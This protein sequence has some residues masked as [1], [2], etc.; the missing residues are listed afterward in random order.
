MGGFCR[1]TVS[2]RGSGEQLRPL[3][4]GARHPGQYPADAR[5]GSG[6][7][8]RYGRRWRGHRRERTGEAL[9]DAHQLAQVGRIGAV[10]VDGEVHEPVANSQPQ[11]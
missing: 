10:P 7:G 2:R 11:E 3:R 4:P 8:E 6:G 5:R 1:E 9:G